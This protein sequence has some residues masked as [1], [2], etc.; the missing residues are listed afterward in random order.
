MTPSRKFVLGF[1]AGH[2]GWLEG[3]RAKSWWLDVMDQFMHLILQM[4]ADK[5]LDRPVHVT[6]SGAV[7]PIAATPAATITDMG[8]TLD[9]PLPAMQADAVL[10]PSQPRQVAPEEFLM[11]GDAE[12]GHGQGAQPATQAAAVGEAHVV[13]VAVADSKDL[14]P[15]EEKAGT[16]GMKHSLSGSVPT[17]TCPAATAPAVLARDVPEAELPVTSLELQGKHTAP[18]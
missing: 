15:A 17:V 8:P 5:L 12:Q 14:S 6:A 3:W 2:L 11:E 9:I 4:H 16:E 18:C 7:M 1:C 13:V 10:Y